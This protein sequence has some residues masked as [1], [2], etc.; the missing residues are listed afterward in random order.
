MYRSLAKLMAGDVCALW[1]PLSITPRKVPQGRHFN[2]MPYGIMPFD[3]YTLQRMMSV[4]RELHLLQSV[5]LE[6]CDQGY[7]VR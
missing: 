6:A 5:N 4:Q 2:L 3:D 1:P 7:E